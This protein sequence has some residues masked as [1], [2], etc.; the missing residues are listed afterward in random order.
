MYINTFINM[1][2]TIKINFIRFNFN[3]CYILL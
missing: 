2:K 3:K 1:V